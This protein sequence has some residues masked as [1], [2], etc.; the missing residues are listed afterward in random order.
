MLRD[1]VPD[2]MTFLCDLPGRRIGIRDLLRPGGEAHRVRTAADTAVHRDRH[3]DAASRAHKGRTGHVISHRYRCLYVKVPKCASTTVLDWFMTHGKGR[4][5]FRPWWY[6]GLLS[7]RIQGVTRGMNLYPDYLTFTFVRNPYERFV[8]IYVYLRRLGVAQPGGAHNH[9]TDY[10]TL[11][12]FAELC[13]EVLA[14]FGPLWGRD[15][16]RFFRENGEREYG[17]GRIKLKHLGF[18]TG[19]ARLQTDFLPDCH[20]E[21]LFGVKR[22]NDDPL[23]FIGAVETIDEDFSRLADMLDLPGIRLSDRNTSGMG[24]RRDGARRYAAY[25]DAATRRLVEDLYTADLDFTGYGFDEGRPMIAVPA[26]K[27]ETPA[28]R[29]TRRRSVGTLLARAWRRL[30]PIEVHFEARILRST[31]VRRLL[32]PLK[33]LRGLPR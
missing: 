17:P 20:P 1:V 31:T 25:Y 27:A 21:R 6:G 13:G 22:V 28:T 8:S 15:A 9:P 10:G 16:R 18:V 2:G 11:R 12:E 26:R 3:C 30:W 32:R 33:R 29:Q 7:D 14:D 5:S 4:H 19:H 24:V 23:S